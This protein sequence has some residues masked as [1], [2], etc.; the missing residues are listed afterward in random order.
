MRSASFARSEHWAMVIQK[1]TD[2]CAPG[3]RVVLIAFKSVQDKAIGVLVILQLHLA[4]V[5]VLLQRIAAP[6]SLA[7]GA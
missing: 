7:G 6:R 5:E 1:L 2:V 4:R 3:I